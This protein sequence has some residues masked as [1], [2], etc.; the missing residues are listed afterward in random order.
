MVSRNSSQTPLLPHHRFILLFSTFF[1]IISLSLVVEPFP[2]RP[3]V[4]FVFLAVALIPKSFWSPLTRLSLFAVLVTGILLQAGGL[5]DEVGTSFLVA[6]MTVKF[7][8]MKT[9]RDA[10]MMALFN[11]VAP[12]TAFLQDQTPLILLCGFLALVFTL[13]LTQSLHNQSFGSRSQVLKNNLMLVGKTFL[14]ILPFAVALYTIAPRLDNPLWEAYAKHYKTGGVS[15]EMNAASWGPVYEDLSTALRLRF[16]SKP[17]ALSQMYLRGMSLWSFDGQTWRA[18][19]Q[20]EEAVKRVHVPRVTK[21]ESPSYTYTVS[22]NINSKYVYS[23]DYPTSIPKGVYRYSD[24]TFIN[25]NF[26][27]RGKSITSTSAEGVFKPLSKAEKTS[28]LQLPESGND[29]TRQ[30]AIEQRAKFK[31]DRAFADFVRSYLKTNYRYTLSP[32]RVGKDSV[33]DFFFDNKQGYCVHFSS[34]FTFIMRAAGIPSRVVTGYV[35]NELSE[36]GDYFRVRQADAHAWSEVWLDDAWVRYDPTT[37]VGVPNSEKDIVWR[38]WNN[39]YASMDW[40]RDAWQRYV[41]YYD[42]NTR[43]QAIEKIQRTMSLKNLTDILKD[44]RPANIV[45]LLLGLVALVSFAWWVKKKNQMKKLSTNLVAKFDLVLCKY[46]SPTKSLPWS[47][48]VECINNIPPKEKEFLLCLSQ[49]INDYVFN[50]K[51]VVNGLG[52]L[53]RIKKAERNRRAL[54]KGK[55]R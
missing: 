34:S 39:S 31:S 18:K 55:Y 17:P 45:F 43:R 1:A 22:Y 8:E 23:L 11:T 19:P 37:S 7:V 36:M 47:K 52:L 9:I 28:A 42:S 49:D 24:D 44:M 4:P 29:K 46:Q 35:A 20:V 50:P 2:L 54:L 40:A 16:E 5:T 32:P 26:R 41:V 13:T 12:F 25:S 6:T 33:D 48:R 53:K 3:F 21:E 30:W 14:F 51:S 10:S 27:F 38:F 15:E